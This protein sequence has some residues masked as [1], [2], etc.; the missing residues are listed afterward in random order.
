MS[1]NLDLTQLAESQ[2]N[3]EIPINDKGAELDAALTETIDVDVS[4]GNVTVTAAQYRRAIRLN[5]INGAVA[6]DV[7]LQA[8]KRLVLVRVD[9]S[10]S[11]PITL[12]LGTTSI[13][14][15]P[16]EMRLIYTDGSANGLEAFPLAGAGSVPFDIGV[17]VPGLPEASGEVL[18]FQVV[19]AFTWPLSLTGSLF[20]A[21]VAAT[22]SSTFT[23]L[24][25]GVSIGSITFG[26]ASDTGSASFGSA[27][28]FA[29]GDQITVTAPSVQD[30]TLEDVSFNFLGAR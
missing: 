10:N 27:V 21:G 1:N 20:K 23:I 14:C 25:N 2:N 7:T 9:S 16:G 24:Q 17:F 12:K 18:R 26:A 29:V 22:A 8:I 4:A 28:T 13:V 19:R 30:A 11:D 3:P 6:R 5:V 15:L